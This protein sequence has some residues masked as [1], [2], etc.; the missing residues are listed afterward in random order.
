M[1]VSLIIPTYSRGEVLCDTIRMALAQ[2]YPDFE[3]IVV[4]QT[5]VVAP[6]VAAYI[7]SLGESIQY[8]QLSPPNLP[9]A[10]NVGVRSAAGDVVIFIDDD[11]CIQPDYIASHVRNYQDG[12]IGAVMGVTLDS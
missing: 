6:K 11:V 7:E 8:H 5:P 12:S 1:K 3:V 10:R 4:D 9:A 2:T